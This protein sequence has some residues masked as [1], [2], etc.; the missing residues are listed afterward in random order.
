MN[1]E[2]I[3]QSKSEREKQISYMN[4]YIWNLERWY[5]FQGGSGDTD[6]ENRLVDTEG[7]GEGGIN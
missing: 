7:D 1:L 4:V 3:I 5:Y 6:I 2:L